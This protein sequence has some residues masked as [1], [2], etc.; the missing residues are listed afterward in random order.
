MTPAMLAAELSAAGA[1]ALPKLVDALNKAGAD[2]QADAKTLAPVDTGNLRA[3]ITR[4][5]ASGVLPSTEVGAEANYGIFVEMGTSRMA[6][7]PYLA[8]AADRHSE[9]LVQAVQQINPLT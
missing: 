8:P 1:R 6:P 3:T 4:T 7:Q 5:P 2:T 9:A